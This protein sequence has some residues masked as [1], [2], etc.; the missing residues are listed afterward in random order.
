MDAPSS[1]GVLH[2]RVFEGRFDGRGSF[3]ARTVIEASVNESS[4]S[5]SGSGT[6]R[7]LESRV[8]PEVVV[9][10]E[11]AVGTGHGAERTTVPW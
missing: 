10:G 2:S 3:I 5:D 9:Y 1:A 6:R 7:F 11:S 4:G 8:A